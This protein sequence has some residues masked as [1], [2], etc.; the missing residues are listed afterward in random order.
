VNVAAQKAADRSP[1]KMYKDLTEARK[2]ETMKRGDYKALVDGNVFIL[3]R[4]V[5]VIKS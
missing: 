5:N 1:L 4:L 2:H 3:V